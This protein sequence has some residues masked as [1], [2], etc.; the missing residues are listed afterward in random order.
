[1]IGTEG[2]TI[3]IDGAPEIV[4]HPLDPDEDFVHVPFVAWSRPASSQPIG[5]TRGEFLAPASHRL[6]GDDDATLSEDQLNI[7]QALA[8]HVVQPDRVADDLGGKPMAVVRI[9]WRFHA[10]SLVRLLACR[11]TWLP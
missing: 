8:E 3:L 5:E 9:G 6:I 4:L 11:Q 10:D 7:P 2:N 1:M